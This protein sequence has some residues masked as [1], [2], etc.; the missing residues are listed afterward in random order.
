MSV[1]AVVFMLSGTSIAGWF[2][3]DSRVVLLTSQLLIVA[4]I[5]QIFDGI[6]V[7]SSG[8]LRG[9]E[10]TRMPMFIGILSYW[11]V[12]LPVS[13]F[14][15]FSLGWGARGIWVGFVVGLAVAAAALL[16]RVFWRFR[17]RA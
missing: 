7:V 14:A 3:Q 15:G 13:W 17:Q 2:V 8:A 1:F 4:G 16:T 6:Q 5:F 11:I 12:A 9:F 10:D